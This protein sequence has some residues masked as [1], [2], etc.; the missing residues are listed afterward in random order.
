MSADYLK[1]RNASHRCK[2]ATGVDVMQQPSEFEER[3]RGE[4]VYAST[5]IK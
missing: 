5:I 1:V 4:S 2:C 3:Y